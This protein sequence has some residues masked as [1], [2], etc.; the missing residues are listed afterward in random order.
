VNG[1]GEPVATERADEAT[2]GLDRL[3]VEALVRTLVES[4]RRAVDAVAAAAPALARAVEEIALRLRAGGHLYY[5]GAGTSGRLAVLDAAEL[6][7]TFGVPPDL[8]QAAIAGGEAALLRAVEGAED[9]AAAGARAG[10]R[11][12]AGDALVALSASGGAAYVVAALEHARSAG[13]YTVA[14][15]SVCDSPLTHA[16]E[17]A[18][19][20]ET[21]SEA[22]AG[23]TRLRAGTAQK[24]AL[25]ALSTAVM[26][27][28]G[29]VYDNLM[30]D[31]VAT[32][33]KLRRRAQRL[34]CTLAE[35]TPERADVLLQEAGG[36]VKIAVV[37]ARRGV[38]A[39]RARSMLAA[40]GD[41]LRAIL[42]S[43]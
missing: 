30:I 38:G 40:A 14:L 34:V 17:L 20:L 21:G 3:P 19:V 22:L 26:V 37:I 32:N 28:L 9:D 25:N 39:A 24:I 35:V 7:P 4:N 27:R 6:P 8:V 43:E 13:A 31:V 5:A 18:I 11:A 41:Q 10:E 23:S 36:S 33:T 29:K 12:G 42:D 16:A 15:T 2:R 1:D